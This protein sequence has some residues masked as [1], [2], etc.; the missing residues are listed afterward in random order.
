MERQDFSE[1][2]H[3]GGKVTFTVKCNEEGHISYQIGYSHSTSGPAALCG[4]YAHPDGFA[5]GNIQMGGIGTPWN[6]PPLPN[7]IAVMMASDSQG[8]FGHECPQCNSHFRSDNIPSKFLLTC[9]YC[10]CRTDSFHF[11]T[12]P[13]NKY[14][15]HYV[16]KLAE[17]IEAINPGGK[18]EVEIDLNNI[19]DTV[20]DK[21]RPDFYYTSTAQQ[22]EFK[23]EKCGSYNDVRGKYA[24]CSSCGWRNNAKFLHDILSS[25]R[26]KLN[27][28]AIS[29]EEAI[30]QSVSEFDSAARNYT[31]QLI[32][33]VP[34]IEARK[35]QLQK[36]LFHNLGNFTPLINAIFGINLL[37]NMDADKDFIN[38][39]FCRRH[40]YEHNGG[41]ATDKYLKESADTDVQEGSL[42]RENQ[43]NANRFIGCLNRMFSLYEAAFHE[44]L[45]PEKFCIDIEEERKARFKAEKDMY[46][47]KS[48][49]SGN[50][51]L[52]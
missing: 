31:E 36:L 49:N 2:G 45:P 34:M 40:I 1:I 20:T 14:I 35:N 21:P 41:V 30:K 24:Y 42:I 46:P 29:P 9:P 23:C 19:A 6:P 47:P 51:K 39:M 50:S 16:D 10:G 13:Q 3:T 38:K 5:C 33:I 32:S 48:D 4:V 43:E 44:L 7:C 17:A 28:G 11:L 52:G 37:Q 12:P 26:E 18:L 8:K 27:S 25:I 15:K 22:T